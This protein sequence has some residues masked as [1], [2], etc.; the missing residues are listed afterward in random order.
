M[1]EAV[2]RRRTQ[3]PNAIRGY[4]AEFGLVAAKGVCKVEPLLARIAGDD[5]LPGLARKLFALAGN[6]PEHIREGGRPTFPKEET[7]PYFFM[8]PPSTSLIGNVRT[9]AEPRNTRPA[10][11]QTA[12]AISMRNMKSR[13][14][15]VTT[16]QHVEIP[17][18]MSQAPAMT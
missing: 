7:Y 3:L 10:S 8:K 13:S 4:A 18:R 16:H 17:K 5:S 15:R 6:Y 14:Y 2:I 9:P 11:T 12:V 1:R